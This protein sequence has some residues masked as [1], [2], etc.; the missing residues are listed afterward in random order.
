MPKAMN[1]LAERAF[2]TDGGRAGVEELLTSSNWE[3]RLEKARA[4]RE[5]VLALKLVQEPTTP[6]D[7]PVMSSSEAAEE[8][9]SIAAASWSPWMMRSV[10]VAV[11][12]FFGLG[13]GL[14]LG[15]GVVFGFGGLPKAQL[16]QGASSEEGAAAMT[17]DLGA[18]SLGSGTAAEGLTA[19]SAQSIA[20]LFEL[21]ALEIDRSGVQN[22]SQGKAVEGAPTVPDRLT[23][24]GVAPPVPELEFVPARGA[25]ASDPLVDA[26]DRSE[27]VESGTDAPPLPL[28]EFAEDPDAQDP[29][30]VLKPPAEVAVAPADAFRLYLYAPDSVAQTALDAQ[31]ARL[32]ESG[33]PIADV[34]RVSFNISAPHIRYYNEQDAAMANTLASNLGVEARAFTDRHDVAA[35]RIEFWLDGTSADHRVVVA[36]H[37]R[38]RNEVANDWV[39]FRDRL[40]RGLR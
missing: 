40:L 30:T 5:K 11:A 32:D 28:F 27:P 19:T 2:V 39:R 9:S 10:F 21:S 18:F 26:P 16:A 1:D 37:R 7:Q 22:L 34:R 12:C 29:A 4:A 36:P 24:D 38:V 20:P 33:L 3:E 31:Q 23:V 13:L 25:V 8:P 35:G 6:P 14:A 17:S 15:F